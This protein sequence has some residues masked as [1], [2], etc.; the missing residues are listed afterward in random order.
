M[1]TMSIDNSVMHWRPPLIELT[2]LG[3]PDL[4]EGQPTVCFVA[5][6]LIS[7]ITRRMLAWSTAASYGTGGRTF[8]PCVPCTEVVY[9]GSSLLVIEEPAQVAA[10]RDRALGHEPPGVPLRVVR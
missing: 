6:D 4:D 5:P 7:S 2:L 1:S 10:L 9:G 8:H 3:N